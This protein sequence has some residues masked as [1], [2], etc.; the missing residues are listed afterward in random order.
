MEEDRRRFNIKHFLIIIIVLLIALAAVISIRS[1]SFKKKYQPSTA[2]AEALP[3]FRLID[4]NDLGIKTD[5][6]NDGINDQEDILLGAKKQLIVPAVNIFSEGIDEPNYYS[7]G[8]PPAD[9]AIST[10]I[11]ARAFL[12]AGFI[13]KDLVYEDISSNFDKYPLRKNWGQTTC[14]SNIDYRRIQNL[15]IFFSRKALSLDIIFDENLPENL[16]SWFPGD[17]VFFDM[18]M[19]GFTDCVSIISGSTTRDGIPKIIYN[20]IEPGHTVEENII[21]EKVVTGHY[22]YPNPQN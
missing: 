2:L 18:N 19:D 20:Y 10:D 6:D 9:L 16:D 17:I 4:M 15:E 11:I 5:Q 21:K 22:R 14:D 12:E 7:G 8:D 3:R 13:L 1:F